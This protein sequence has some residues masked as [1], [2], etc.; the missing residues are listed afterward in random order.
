MRKVQVRL[1]DDQSAALRSIAARTGQR[2]SDLIRKGVDLLIE[3]A[4]T[5]DDAWREG[6]L[7]V[8]GAWAG[9]EDLPK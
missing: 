1:R 6:L 2:P 4:T 7:S 9:R 3:T 5:D 8:A